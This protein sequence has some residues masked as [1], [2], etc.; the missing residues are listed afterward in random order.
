M[1]FLLK[2]IVSMFIMP[3]PLAMLLL[4][5]GLVFLYKNKFTQ[6]KITL[7]MGL[8]WLFLISYSPLINTILY[9]YEA[10]YPTLKQAP[11]GIKY[12][13]VLGGGHHT[14]DDHPITSQVSESSSIR[15]N[16]GIRLYQQLDK[17]VHIIVSGYSG[18]YDPTP[19]A[20]M[21]EKLACALGVTATDLILHPNPRD[22]HEEAI[23]AKQR[24]GDEPFILVTSASHMKRALKYFRDEGLDP[25]PAPTN[26]L[27]SIKHPNYTA[28]FSISALRKSNIVWYE[29]LGLLWQK[30]KGI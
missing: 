3:F 14:D 12:I 28:V 18:L 5:L 13:Y 7:T 17:D 27:A 1:D 10:S 30:I 19:H 25:I 22:T 9:E 20:V 4:I 16:E 24:I 11:K 23:A 21:Q 26:H 15:L 6:A 29:M 8:V 2:K